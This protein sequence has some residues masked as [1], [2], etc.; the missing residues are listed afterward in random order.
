MMR[1][2]TIQLCNSRTC[3]VIISHR[4]LAKSIRRETGDPSILQR[5]KIAS[6]ADIEGK[7][8]YDEQYDR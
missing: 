3:F 5:R 2:N 6:N 1:L 8:A 7:G 4:Y